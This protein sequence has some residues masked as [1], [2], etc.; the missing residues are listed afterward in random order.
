[1]R[2][3]RTFVGATAA[4][5]AFSIAAATP[6]YT[7]ESAD[8]Y[9]GPVRQSG[10]GEAYE[11]VKP[12]NPKSPI[13]AYALDG[14]PTG[15]VFNGIKWGG[16]KPCKDGQLRISKFT[17]VKINNVLMYMH[18]GNAGSTS[19][20]KEA[21]RHGYVRADDLDP[22]GLRRLQ[23]PVTPTSPNGRACAKVTG[24]TYYNNPQ[25]IPR[26]FQYKRTESSS[27]WDNYGDPP[28]SDG[29]YNPPGVHYNYVNWSWPV[30]S[31]GKSNPGGGQPRA[32]IQR[33]AQLSVCDVQPIVSRA[34]DNGKVVGYV[35]GVYV[36]AQSNSGDAVHGW[37]VQSWRY[38]NSDTWHD[39]LSPNPV[40]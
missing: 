29:T 34:Y 40:P 35:R 21:I 7:A 6:A 1:M 15:F 10:K 23:D 9:N 20:D 32:V 38:N 22:A 8:K 36:R 11:C 31:K 18:R 5:L 30:D 19:Q 39:L 33:N 3:T 13:L 24:Q 12:K 14:S 26:N 28:Q 4:A 17:P 16:S 25:R 37:V 2:S 27:D